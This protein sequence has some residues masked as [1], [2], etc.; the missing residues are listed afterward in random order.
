MASRSARTP[1]PEQAARECV[2]K[3]LV[4]SA[5]RPPRPSERETPGWARE[6]RASLG[7]LRSHQPCEPERQR[8]RE[9]WARRTVESPC[10]SKGSRDRPAPRGS[11]HIDQVFVSAWPIAVAPDYASENPG[12]NRVGLAGAPGHDRSAIASDSRPEN[13]RVRR[14]AGP[15]LLAIACMARPGIILPHYQAA[16]GVASEDRVGAAR[17][18]SRSPRLVRSSN[19]SSRPSTAA[20]SLAKSPDRT[21]FP[22]MPLPR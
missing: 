6:R 19:L 3:Q 9:P 12:P 20:R 5:W 22:P 4:E 14:Y 11:H 21:Y 7:E 15:Q 17:M 1:T 2:W 18:S 10:G 13:P 16:R 8:R